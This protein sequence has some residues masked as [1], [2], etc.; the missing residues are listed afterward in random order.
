M[1]V[2]NTTP[3]SNFLHLNRMDILQHLF[4]HIHIPQV[5]REELEEF[6]SAHEQL[7]KALQDGFL[8]VHTIQSSVILKQFLNVLHQ[9]EAEAIALAEEINA[10]LIILDDNRARRT[11]SMR[12]LRVVGTLSLLRRAEERG[13]IPALKPL[14]DILMSAGFYMGKEYDE[15]LHDA[16]EL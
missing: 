9:G 1:I 16:G 13:F 10:D 12:G 7:Q 15:V 4:T 8:V 11:A 6:F 3:L 14:L 5:V 2:S